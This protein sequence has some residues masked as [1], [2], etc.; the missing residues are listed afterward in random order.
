M[1]ITVD[2][3]VLISSSFWLGNSD[4]IIEMAESGKIELILS[5]DIIE[6]FVRV[7][8]YDEIKDKVREK[9]LEMRRSVEKLISISTIV[10]PSNTIDIIKDD[11]KDNIIL[12]CAVEGMA[13]YIISY[14]KHLLKLRE[15]NGIKIVTPEEFL[16]SVGWFE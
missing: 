12:E 10:F 7:L 14:D 16:N 9:E 5:Q 3:N 1:K 6:E 2:T 8:G 15:F 11:L 4:K 13:D